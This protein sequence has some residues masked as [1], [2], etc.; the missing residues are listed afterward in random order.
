MSNIKYPLWICKDVSSDDEECH[1]P[2]FIYK[3]NDNT[4]MIENILGGDGANSIAS[5]TYKIFIDKKRLEKELHKTLIMLIYNPSET[6]ER[7]KKWVEETYKKNSSSN[8][9]PS[10]DESE[11]PTSD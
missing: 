10:S 9:D 7:I 4:F 1:L 6:E 3:I 11:D 2:V 8:E 5:F